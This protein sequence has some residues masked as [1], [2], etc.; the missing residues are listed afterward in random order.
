MYTDYLYKNSYKSYNIDYVREDD[1]I[2]LESKNVEKDVIED[3]DKKEIENNINSNINS[4]N[5]SINF[6]AKSNQN[7]ESYR[8]VISD[9]KKEMEEKI[10]RIISSYR[11]NVNNSKEVNVENAVNI[12]IEKSTEINKEKDEKKEAKKTKFVHKNSWYSVEEDDDSEEENNNQ[13]VQEKEL[14]KERDLEINNREIMEEKEVYLTKEG[15][16]KLEEE[17]KILKTEERDNIEERIKVAKSFGDLSENSEYDEARSAQ[18]ANENK[19]LEIEQMLKKA[20]IIDEKDIDTTTVQIGNTIYITN[21]ANN[22]EQ[23]YT[24]VG[25]AEAN[26]LQG[27]ISNESPIAKSLLRSKSWRCSSSR[28]TCRDYRI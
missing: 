17:L 25:T 22:K 11:E 10:D 21:I 9:E 2:I 4:Y 13:D 12:A 3:L 18:A 27:K 14:D 16:E 24:I 5:N 26:V 6:G 19:I 7:G 28:S 20:K 15:Y 8:N 23:K 1:D